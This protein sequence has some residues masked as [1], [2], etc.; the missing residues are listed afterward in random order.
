M[1]FDKCKDCLHE[2]ICELYDF[3]LSETEDE[4]H[5]FLT[6]TGCSEQ[7]LGRKNEDETFGF[8]T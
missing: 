6:R 4:C 3:S 2:E 1:S 5:Y 7:G 8:E